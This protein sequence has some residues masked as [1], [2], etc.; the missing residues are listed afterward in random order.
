M[1]FYSIQV[2]SL[3]LIILIISQSYFS[4][5]IGSFLSGI[6]GILI[7]LECLFYPKINLRFNKL[8][9]ASTLYATG[10]AIVFSSA[11]GKLNLYINQMNLST[12]DLIMA[13]VFIN[14]Y[15]LS[16]IF[17]PNFIF[18]FFSENHPNKETKLFQFMLTE[19]YEISLDYSKFK[20]F[21]LI[22][23]FF[24][25][26][27]WYLLSTGQYGFLAKGLTNDLGEIN[28]IVQMILLVQPLF[29]FVLGLF[30]KNIM[31]LFQNS[32]F[33]FF[34]LIIL[35][36]GQS[37]WVLVSSL[38]RTIIGVVLV[39]IFA[40]RISYLDKSTRGWLK[41]VMIQSL[42]LCF[43]G[44]I[45][46]YFISFFRFIVNSEFSGGEDISSFQILSLAMT[47][48]FTNF[49]AILGDESFAQGIQENISTRGIV[50]G[51]LALIMNAANQ[52]K[53]S[54]GEGEFLL[55]NFLAI[56]PSVFLDYFSVFSKQSLVLSETFYHQAFMLSKTYNDVADSLYLAAFVDFSWL[57]IIIIPLIIGSSFELIF[58]VAKKLKSELTYSLVFS[59]LLSLCLVNGGEGT[60]QGFFTVCRD[61]I[62]ACFL[63]YSL[64]AC[65]KNSLV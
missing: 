30:S 24:S 15:A 55:N 10:L 47:T 14:L 27:Q 42:P 21:I 22:S 53:V 64:R 16:L 18:S 56:I 43:I 2:L 46:F 19:I 13:Q 62:F 39:Y 29:F 36:M 3:G 58:L 48:S 25:A 61:L 1:S 63:F 45:G 11:S 65:L 40:L 33:Y 35:I 17:I 32:T 23:L 41:P 31:K 60:L 37:Y 8:L 28:P 52:Y 20:R 50:S 5:V 51:A 44:I 9:A 49:F 26:Y 59:I 4:L 38:R 54:F 34:C 7:L 12:D 57:G 6:S